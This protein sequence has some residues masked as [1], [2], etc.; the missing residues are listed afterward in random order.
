MVIGGDRDNLGISH[1][2]LRIKRGKLQMLLV[3]FRAVVAARKCQDQRI[4]ALQFAEPARCSRVIGQLIVRENGS[5]Y[6]VVSH[7]GTPFT[8]AN[9]VWLWTITGTLKATVQS[10]E[11]RSPSTARSTGVGGPTQ[12]VDAV[13]AA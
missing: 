11:R 13:R 7:D 12:L 9:Q 10:L 6:E 8:N 3:L 5:G 1:S 4:V 2:D